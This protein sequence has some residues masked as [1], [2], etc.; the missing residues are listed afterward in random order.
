[1][2]SDAKRAWR[3]A[4]QRPAPPR[5]AKRWAERAGGAARAGPHV[6]RDVPEH[7]AAAG[8]AALGGREAR[9]VRRLELAGPAARGRTE[10][11]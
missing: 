9:I 5:A 7:D 4:S 6:V 10:R 1:M 11:Q 2:K 3:M 8:A